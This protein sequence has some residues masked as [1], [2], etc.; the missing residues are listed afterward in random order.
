M[1]ARADPIR[2]GF[3]MALTGSAA[4]NGKVAIIAMKIWQDD[5]NAKGGLLGRPV[6]LDYYDDQSNPGN[7]PGIY[8]KLLDV[9]KVELI[10]GPYSTVMT[11]PAMPIVMQHNMVIV[12]LT[13]LNINEQFHYPR[14]FAMIQTGPHPTLVRPI[15]DSLAHVGANAMAVGTLTRELADGEALLQ[16]LAALFVRGAAIDLGRLFATP[17]PLALAWYIATSAAAKRVERSWP[18]AG[19][20]AT[21]RLALTSSRRPLTDISA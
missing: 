17:P 7:V 2:I 11:A 12:S 4:A 1:A 5:I 10:V 9:D 21:P 6:E 16:T 13:A 14:Y 19:A 20:T 18:W 3:S 8:T 15:A